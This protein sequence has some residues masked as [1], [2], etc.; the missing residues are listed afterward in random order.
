V[1]NQKEIGQ[2]CGEILTILNLRIV[3]S[4]PNQIPYWCYNAKPYLKAI[5]DNDYGMDDPTMCVLYALSNLTSWRGE[6]AR[7]LKAEL[8][9]LIKEDLH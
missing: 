4:H 9:R 7:T 8:N 1:N 3:S 5:R 2:V 6:A